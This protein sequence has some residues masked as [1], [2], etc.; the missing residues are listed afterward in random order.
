MYPKN[1]LELALRVKSISDIRNPLQYRVRAAKY[2]LP[3]M[4]YVAY[5][6]EG[7]TADEIWELLFPGFRNKKI[8]P[9]PSSKA[10]KNTQV[11]E[12]SKVSQPKKKQKKEEEVFA[13]KR[14]S[15]GYLYQFDLIVKMR[16]MGMV[17]SETYL[18]SAPLFSDWPNNPESYY[19]NWVG[20][21][22]FFTEP[23]GILK[24]FI[25]NQ[26]L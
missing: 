10:V 26:Y 1:L 21:E 6:N 7:K 3:S 23:L 11:L 19:D 5:R 12:S 16:E 20:W 13:L 17:D 4:P 25:Q 18:R 9:I 15:M 2:N 8:K 22:K 24:I 14:D